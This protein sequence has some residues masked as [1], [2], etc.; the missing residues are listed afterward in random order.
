L[1]TIVQYLEAWRINTAQSLYY[2]FKREIILWLSLCQNFTYKNCYTEENPEWIQ[3]EINDIY[4]RLFWKKYDATLDAY[5]VHYCLGNKIPSI[6]SSTKVLSLW[7]FE[8]D[9]DF[10]GQIDAHFIQGDPL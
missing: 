4:S 10:C 6:K 8:S 1:S 5:Y 7:V 9:K 2:S 3:D